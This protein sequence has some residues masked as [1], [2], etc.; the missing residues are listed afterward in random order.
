[1][2]LIPALV[3]NNCADMI[4]F[5]EKAFG[6]H[7][8]YRLSG[9][10]G[11][12]MHC[13]MMLGESKIM[14]SDEMPKWNKSFKTLGGSPVVMVLEIPDVDLAYEKAISAGAISISTPADQ[15]HGDRTARV[16]DP[17]GFNWIL[18]THLKNM[19]QQEMQTAMEEWMKNMP[20]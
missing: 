3:L 9:P 15:F 13:E 5:Y 7:E 8:L 18:S 12:I 17:N 1:M 4:K 14:V 11:S 10:D 6:G 20:S 19:S 16:S 2:T